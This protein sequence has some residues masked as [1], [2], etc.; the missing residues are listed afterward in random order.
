MKPLIIIIL[1][2]FA[3]LPTA[4]ARA[5]PGEE[6]KQDASGRRT[7]PLIRGTLWWLDAPFT[8]WPKDELQR[9][10]RSQRDVGFDLLW[11]LNTP[12]LLDRAERASTP[13]AD[14]LET[15][16][17]IA[18]AEGM[19]IIADLPQGGWYRKADAKEMLAANTKHIRRYQARYG[20]H[21]SFWGW[22]LNYEIN[23]IEP[24]DVEQTA[25]WRSLWRGI[26]EECHRAAPGSVV[27]IS[28]FFLLDAA[29]RRGFVYLTPEQYA[30]WWGETMRETGIDILMLQDS[31]EHLS[32]FTLEQREPFFAAMAEA[33][34]KAGARFWVNV[35]TGEM[36]VSDWDGFLALSRDNK[37][38]WRFT[39]IDWLQQKLD[40]AAR[41]GD[42]IVN[43]GYYPF[44][45]PMAAKPP[46]GK[47]SETS[48][49]PREAYEDYRAYHTRVKH[50]TAHK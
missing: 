2:S 20:R 22:Y 48:R 5:E 47:L 42:G 44:M 25:F 29:R 49:T 14:V 23:P 46:P 27:T 19:R 45:D 38:P 50:Q 34:H 7:A 41:H 3:L 11:L 6:S 10:I 35:E 18:D 15:I 16:Y 8:D 12:A 43:W 21:A 4:P 37:T 26:A 9:A 40:L 33:C 31:G 28:P 39:P 30:A 36:H 24:G 1:V 32:F 17:G 13:G